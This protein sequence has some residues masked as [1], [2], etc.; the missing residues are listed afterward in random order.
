MSEL[1][2]PSNR[3]C[4]VVDTFVLVVRTRISRPGSL[5]GS[6]LTRPAIG[7]PVL[8]GLFLVFGYGL[9]LIAGPVLARPEIWGVLFTSLGLATLACLPAIAMVLYLDRREPEPW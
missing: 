2:P 9:W 1:A 3:V 5:T 6:P 8:V 4:H 7:I